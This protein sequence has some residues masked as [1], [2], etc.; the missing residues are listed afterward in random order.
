MTGEEFINNLRGPPL[1]KMRLLKE[2]GVPATF[3]LR[4]GQRSK[5][6]DVLSPEDFNFVIHDQTRLAKPEFDEFAKGGA[7]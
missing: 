4:G 1:D 2:A 7:V 3:F 6:P 5:L